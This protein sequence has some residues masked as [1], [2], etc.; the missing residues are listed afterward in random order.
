MSLW[1]ILF[2]GWKMKSTRDRILRTLL[3]HPNA[4]IS[5]LATSVSINSISVR[6]HLTNLLADGLIVANEVRHGVG[7]PRLVYSL[8]EAGQE[9]FPTRYM[10]LT[11]KLLDQLKQTLSPVQVQE[12]FSSI[13]KSMINDDL[14]KMKKL[15]IEQKLEFIKKKL[16]DE[17][18]LI[19]WDKN[20]DGYII[21]EIS[22][23]Y[24]H[25]GQIHPEVCIVDQTLISTV[26]SKKTIKIS[27]VL[28]GDQFCKYLIQK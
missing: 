19:E 3:N 12:V 18:F 10:T 8:S 4:S 14:E 11:N 13:A 5:D 22:C 23:P 17:G 25:I 6:H 2:R 28:N 21:K 27:C 9:N 24:Y 26:L 1:Y 16:A 15:S 7:R 20:D